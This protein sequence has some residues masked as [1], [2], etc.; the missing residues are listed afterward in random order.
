VDRLA[1]KENLA[2]ISVRHVS[3]AYCNRP[4]WLSSPVRKLPRASVSPVGQRR[5]WSL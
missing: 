4:S 3:A 1:L 5:S 2:S